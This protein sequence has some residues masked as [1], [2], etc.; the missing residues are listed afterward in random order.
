MIT[1]NTTPNYEVGSYVNCGKHGVGIIKK[2]DKRVVGSVSAGFYI[3]NVLSS[4]I[5]VIHPVSSADSMCRKLL[6]AEEVENVLNKNEACSEMTNSTWNRRYREH[7]EKIESGLFKDWVAVAK[8]LLMVRLQK[9][10][11]FG[12][13]KMFDQVIQL[14]VQEIQIGSSDNRP[15]DEIRIALLN[16][17]Q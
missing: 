12:E 1:Q 16:R 13:R 11:S 15:F 8:T 6:T 5:T 9:D 4:E 7:M 14:L 10:L 3:I 17:L 2:I